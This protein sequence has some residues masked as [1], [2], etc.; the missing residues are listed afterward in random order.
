MYIEPDTE[1]LHGI[2]PFSDFEES[3]RAVMVFLGTLDGADFWLDLKAYKP[4]N[5]CLLC[6]HP[7]NADRFRRWPIWCAATQLPQ[8]AAEVGL[9]PVY[10]CWLYQAIE[11]AV[12]KHPPAE[13]T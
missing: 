6:V 12:A 8:E 7:D 2:P 4:G 13:D 3:N 9:P 1:P 5:L 11:T 10:L